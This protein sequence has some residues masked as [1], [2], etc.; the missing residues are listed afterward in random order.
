[1]GGLNPTNPVVE[2]QRKDTPGL[3]QQR[4]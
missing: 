3:I 4:L 2:R 1:M